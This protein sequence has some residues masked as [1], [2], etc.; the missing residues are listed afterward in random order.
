MKR[1]IC[2][3][4]YYFLV[5]NIVQAKQLPEFVQQRLDSIKE[6]TRKSLIEYRYWNYETNGYM[7]IPFNLGYFSSEYIFSSEETYLIDSLELNISVGM[8][9]DDKMRER[10]VQLMQNKYREDELDTLVNRRMGYNLSSYEYDAMEMCKFDT[11]RIF[12]ITLDSLY[13]DIKSKEGTPYSKSMYKDRV[14]KLLQ[15][16]T[17]SIYKQIRDKVIKRERERD[18]SYLIQMILIYI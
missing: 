15:L 10:I 4:I 3:I 11:M 1:I 5:L 2:I 16:D 9:Y 7:T 17:T 12:K 13:M 14:F 6:E 18:K 8:I